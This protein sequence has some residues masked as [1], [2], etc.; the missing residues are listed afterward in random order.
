[1]HWVHIVPF[2][3]SFLL[4]D[5]LCCN[6][7]NILPIFLVIFNVGSLVCCYNCWLLQFLKR[8]GVDSLLQSMVVAIFFKHRCWF[9]CYINQCWFIGVVIVVGLLLHWSVLVCYYNWSTLQLMVAKVNGCCSDWMLLKFLNNFGC[10]N[11]LKAL[12][13]VHCCNCWNVFPIQVSTVSME[14]Q[15]FKHI[16]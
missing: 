6:C 16:L 7:W 8:G 3:F 1:M 15:T 2:F 5:F 12:M 10:Y 11:F 13:L 14:I 9:C 4:C